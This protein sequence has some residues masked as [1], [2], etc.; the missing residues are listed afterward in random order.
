MYDEW[1]E[2]LINDGKLESY[3][4]PEDLLYFHW[5]EYPYVKPSLPNKDFKSMAIGLLIILV[6]SIIPIL[7]LIKL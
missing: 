6:M 1:V 3:K 2:K 5:M 7:L 4:K